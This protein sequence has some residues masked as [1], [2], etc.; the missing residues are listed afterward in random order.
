MVGFK[1]KDSLVLLQTL[2]RRTV[3]MGSEAGSTEWCCGEFMLAGPGCAVCCG[4]QRLVV[5]G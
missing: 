1:S 3:G 4:E 2:G 5:G